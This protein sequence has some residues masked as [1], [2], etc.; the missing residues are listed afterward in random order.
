MTGISMSKT[1]AFVSTIPRETWLNPQTVTL[2]GLLIPAVASGS[3]DFAVECNENVLTGDTKACGSPAKVTVTSKG[4]ATGKLSV[5]MGNVGDGTCGTGS[6]DEVCYIELV[7]VT[8]TLA[9]TPIA[10]EPIDFYE[11]TATTNVVTVTGGGTLAASA[12]KTVLTD[13]EVSVTCSAS[14]ASTTIGNGTS[15]AK[16]PHPIGIA[17]DL[18]FSKCTGPLGKVTTTPADEPYPVNVNS[19]TTSGATAT[20]ISDIDVNVAMT[21]CSFTVTGSAPGDYSNSSHTLA[22][23]PKPKPKG[24]TK[25]ELTVSNV[26]GCAGLVKNGDHPTY[27]SS[28]KLSRAT[29]SIKSDPPAT[30]KWTDSRE[31]ARPNHP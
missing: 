13:G 31:S 23:T 9:I 30:K 28:Y 10:S 7:N 8:S 22:M 26:S 27:T 21:G 4:K 5:A 15:S 19:A 3:A 25:A 18:T 1:A 12:A 16:A 2:T 24:L 29:L 14:T 11:A 17:A 20:T 6:A